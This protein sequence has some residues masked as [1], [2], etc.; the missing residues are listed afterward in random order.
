MQSRHLNQ[1]FTIIPNTIVSKNTRGTFKVLLLAILLSASLY[2]ELP[3]VNAEFA[4]KNVQNGSLLSDNFLTDVECLDGECHVV[5]VTISECLYQFNKPVIRY[6]KAKNLVWDDKTLSLTFE[7]QTDNGEETWTL[8]LGPKTN[9]QYSILDFKATGENY[10]RVPLN[11]ELNAVVK[12]ELQL[13][14]KVEL[15]ILPGK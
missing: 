4:I 11:K 12:K 13:D 6:H 15:P 1:R 7:I 2:A 3:K 9:G 10:K 8:F 14:C 5:L